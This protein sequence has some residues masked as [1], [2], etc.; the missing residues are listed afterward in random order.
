MLRTQHKSNGLRTK[1]V[2]DEPWLYRHRVH[3]HLR[4]PNSTASAEEEQ[5]YYSR[6]RS[7]R[8]EVEDSNVL[9]WRHRLGV[10]LVRIA[11][12]DTRN[13]VLAR[14]ARGLVDLVRVGASWR[15]LLVLRG[16]EDMVEVDKDW[17][18]KDSWVDTY[19]VLRQHRRH[20][21]ATSGT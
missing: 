8:G 18:G 17:S 20:L 16:R 4:A 21:A 15:V 13:C 6:Y 2:H 12:L 1:F 10:L 14:E 11:N 19:P 5:C 9:H 3:R 7:S